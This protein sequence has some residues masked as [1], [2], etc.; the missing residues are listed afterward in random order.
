M[1]FF[2]I[3]LLPFTASAFINQ[4]QQHQHPTASTFTSTSVNQNTYRK[5]CFVKY[6]TAPKKQSNIVGEEEAPA[7]I[8]GAE[9]FGGSKQKDELFDVEEE[10]KAGTEIEQG[11][12]VF[13]RFYQGDGVPSEAFDTILSAKVAF[14]LQSQINSALYE[15]AM[16]P[17]MDFT[18]SSNLEWET[19]IKK[20]TKSPLKE[21]EKG[22]EFYKNIDLAIVSGKQIND[23]TIEFQWELSVVWPTFW[24]PRVLLVGSSVCTLEGSAIVRQTDKL[25]DDMDLLNCVQS[26]VK[27]RFWD[28]YHIGMSP[29][30]EQMP[31]LSMEKSSFG[32]YQ[33][34]EIPSRLVSVPTID[35]SGDR[36]D[37]NAET[38]P[39][40]AFSCIIKTMGPNR[41][42]YVPTTPVEVQ[43]IP[44]GERLKLK[45][46]IPLAVE[47]LTNAELPIA[48]SDDETDESAN[49]DC[50]YEFQARRK[51][52]TVMYGGNAQDPDISDVRKKLYEK[53]IK[54]GLTPKLDEN[55]RPNFF[56]LQ[57]TVKACYTEEG[58]GMAVYEWR[59]KLVKPNEVGIELEL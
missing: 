39:N 34:Y 38:I 35:E 5:T 48:G 30:A 56:F 16:D 1:S 50:T 27:P 29:S 53:V 36:E 44:G 9:F 54:D 41:Q 43:I 8:G 55:G 20:E 51:V 40:H 13:N 10:N 52:A 25:I 28:W 18:Y 2:V 33:V 7:G 14:S 26:Q 49:P 17:N 32:G 42:R 24:A 37:R 45:W 4:N 47:F 11:A 19:P 15:Q 12:G 59:P 6:S 23:S 22:L 31:Q 58:L 46:T 57:N 21:V 3:M